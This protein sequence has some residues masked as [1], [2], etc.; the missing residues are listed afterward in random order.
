MAARKPR[1]FKLFIAEI[2]ADR[3]GAAKARGRYDA[4]A[5]SATTQHC[6]CI[7]RGYSSTRDRMKCNSQRFHQ[8]EFFASEPCRI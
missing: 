1:E 8:T 4:K 5:D 3:A 6:H 2:N 7:V